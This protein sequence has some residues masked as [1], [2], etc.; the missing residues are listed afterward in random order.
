M[1]TWKAARYCWILLLICPLANAQ[2][3]EAT[4]ADEE[5]SDAIVCIYSRNID[6][7]D[8]LTDEHV[9]I[10]ARRDENYLFTMRRRCTGL[11]SAMGIAIKGTTSRVCAD[12]FGEI[13]YRDMGRRLE[14][15]RIDNIERVESKDAAKE[16]IKQREEEEN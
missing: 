1:N 9:F 16:L 10:S 2:D 8:A 15:C 13:V 7:F 5:E 14:S 6:G 3:E 12:G 4:N 11:R